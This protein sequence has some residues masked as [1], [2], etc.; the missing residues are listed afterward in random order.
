MIGYLSLDFLRVPFTIILSN[1]FNYTI[2]TNGKVQDGPITLYQQFLACRDFDKGAIAVVL[3]LASSC[4][5]LHPAL[6]SK[7]CCV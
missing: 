4:Q 1:L 3:S 6:S 7:I 5:R 2:L